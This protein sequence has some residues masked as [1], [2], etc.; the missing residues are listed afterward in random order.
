[1]RLRDRQRLVAALVALL[2]V[3]FRPV[4]A[5]S[6][7][8]GVPRT[9]TVA[10][11][12]EAGLVGG[13]VTVE[14]D[15]SASGGGYLMFS[16]PALPVDRQG[17]QVAGNRLVR[18]GAPFV[19]VG[20]TMV[21]TASPTAEGET[22]WAARRLS[23]A[24]MEA[25]I[26][27]GANTLRFQVSQ[28]G[29]DPTDVL[30]SDA[31]VERI[32][33]AVALARARG[34]VVILSVQDQGPTAGGSHAQPSDATIRDWETLTARFNGDLDV[35]Y[36]M[37]NEPQNH[38]TP[39][40]WS[41]WRDGGPAARNQGTPAVG[42][43]AVLDAIRA[44]GARN[45]VVADAGQFGQRLD[46]IPLVHDPLG[47]VA[48]GVHPYLTAILRDP[49]NWEPS[50][51]FLARQFPVVATE[52]IANSRVVFCHPEWATTAPQLLDFLQARGIGILAW[53][54]DVLDSLIVDFH[55]TP[56]TLDGFQCGEFDQGAGALVKARLPG[57]GPLVSGCETGL[58][59][60]GAVALPVDIPEDGTYHLWSLINRRDPSWSTT[61]SM[62]Q[63]DDGCLLPAW[64]SGSRR[65]IWSWRPGP[66]AGL[67][68]TAGRHTF[69]FFGPK[70]GVDLDRL[71]L[72]TDPNHAPGG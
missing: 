62:L 14:Q 2:T 10:I 6:P 65:G 59:D 22:A 18:S 39:D 53:A 44:T 24:D 9:P 7:T 12:A 8:G 37:F 17:V 26:G 1:M 43:Q 70:T 63:V 69:R 36:E 66:D 61:V 13:R 29:L 25:A 41:V 31:Y 71:V 33:A 45:V 51:G 54:F 48:Y 23:D 64:T 57:W 42:H 27:W 68:L 19:P 60:E 20:F 30:Y 21:A 11:E 58:S 34:L 28:R 56:T 55:H 32:A 38:A 50:F 4:L 46:G 3:P 47:Q 15:E 40:G 5:G 49:A 16:G 67:P 72:S 52:W 35:M